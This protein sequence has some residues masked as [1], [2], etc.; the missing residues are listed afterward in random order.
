MHHFHREGAEGRLV[1]A[2]VQFAAVRDAE[3][4]NTPRARLL[5]AHVID[6]ARIIEGRDPVGGYS[7][8]YDR[9]LARVR[10]GQAT[11]TDADTLELA[12]A[13]ARGELSA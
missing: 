3:G 4:A 13:A 1:E 6:L 11:E 2:A 5:L 8:P 9:A 7:H 10:A 12:V